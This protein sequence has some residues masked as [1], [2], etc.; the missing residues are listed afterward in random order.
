MGSHPELAGACIF[1]SGAEGP[2]RCLSLGFLD[3]RQPRCTLRPH[4]RTPADD[5]LSIDQNAT[6]YGVAG[7]IFTFDLSRRIRLRRKA[8][9][10]RPSYPSANILRRRGENSARLLSSDRGSRLPVTAP[11][12]R[13][14][15]GTHFARHP[16]TIPTAADDSIVRAK[17]SDA[18]PV[19]SDRLRHPPIHA[20]SPPTA[21]SAM[22]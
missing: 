2:W 6:S 3:L 17:A 14:D 10:L 5:D 12:G 8:Q 22:T 13:S 9:R 15:P 4:G 19:G 1:P 20:V 18:A 16:C 7:Y 21:S 11:P